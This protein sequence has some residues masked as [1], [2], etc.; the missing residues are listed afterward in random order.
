MSATRVPSIA[1][2]SATLPRLITLTQPRSPAAEAYRTLRTNLRFS[3]PDHAIRVVLVT[4]AGVGE[5]KSTVLANL[6]VVS[7][8]TGA[9]VIA[10]DTDLR[11]PTLHEL[12]GVARAPG[13]T[14]AVL[15][16]PGQPPALQNTGVSSLHLLTS[17]VPAPNP[18]EVLASQGTAAL[19]ASL[20]ADADLVLLDSPPVGPVADAAV[21]AGRADGVVF[22]IRYRKTSRGAARRALA[23]LERI[24]ARLL[25]SVIN[26]APLDASMK[27]YYNA[28]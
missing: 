20:A 26:E 21:L 23:Q 11:R 16:G 15:A 22:V 17:G 7:A 14:D 8:E 2:A 18:A 9:R 1:V 19:I 25:G 27:R 13:L 3:A 12:F 5:G 24:D 28:G 10:V 4:S 6:A